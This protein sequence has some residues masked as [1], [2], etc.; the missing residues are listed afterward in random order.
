MFS[1]SSDAFPKVEVILECKASPAGFDSQKA[2]FEF[3]L[4]I[5]Q[6]NGFIL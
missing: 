6:T 2:L 3:K 5:Q 4:G 1:I